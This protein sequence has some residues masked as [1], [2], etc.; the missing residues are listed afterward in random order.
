MC[1]VRLQ[2]PG[3]RLIKYTVCTGNAKQLTNKYLFT[4]YYQNSM[5]ITLYAT[6]F[7]SPSQTKPICLPVLWLHEIPK[8]CNKNIE[9]YNQNT[10]IIESMANVCGIYFLAKTLKRKQSGLWW[11]MLSCHAHTSTSVWFYDSPTNAEGTTIIYIRPRLIDNSQNCC[12][13]LLFI[14]YHY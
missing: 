8:N 12:A 3:E 6:P 14:I 13:I 1:G 9:R 4:L 5:I 2:K 7:F 11:L 10:L